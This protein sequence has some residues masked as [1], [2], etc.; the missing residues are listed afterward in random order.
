MAIRTHR[1]RLEFDTALAQTTHVPIAERLF[2]IYIDTLNRCLALKT[3]MRLEFDRR[4]VRVTQLVDDAGRFISQ[5]QTLHVYPDEHDYRI[6]FYTS[7]TR[8]DAFSTLT[9]DTNGDA[10]LCLCNWPSMIDPAIDWVG[11]WWHIRSMYHEILHT[12]GV[13]A[14]GAES[15]NGNDAVDSSGDEP[16]SNVNVMRPPDPYWATRMTR[17]KSPMCSHLSPGHS[18]FPECDSLE[19]CIQNNAIT[20]HEAAIVNGW[21]RGLHPAP[22]CLDMNAIRVSVNVPARIRVW[23]CPRTFYDGEWEVIHQAVTLVVPMETDFAWHPQSWNRPNACIKVVAHGY[24]SQA[25]WVSL[26]DLEEAGMRGEPEP[27]TVRINLIPIIQH[28][29]WWSTWQSVSANHARLLAMW[30]QNR[31]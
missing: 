13:C 2:P 8:T 17:Y 4:D 15:Y 28:P 21:H 6:A 25:V 23:S 9:N 26:F 22:R 10:V 16:L 12:R 31:R 3:R 20:D 29:W 14:Q 18:L 7:R 19:W 27:F 5:P 11:F 30:R 24:E 1:V